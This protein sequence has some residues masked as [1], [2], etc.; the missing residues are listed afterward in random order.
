[1]IVRCAYCDFTVDVG[2]VGDLLTLPLGHLYACI[3]LTD[4]AAARLDEEGDQE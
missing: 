4:Q 3:D 1:M 2:T